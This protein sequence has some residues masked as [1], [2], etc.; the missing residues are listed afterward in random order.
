MER[1]FRGALHPPAE[2]DRAVL[3]TDLR[4]LLGVDE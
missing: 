1:R 2:G 3:E 4:P